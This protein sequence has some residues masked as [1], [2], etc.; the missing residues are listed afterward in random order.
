LGRR[1]LAP[2]AAEPKASKRRGLG[3]R[4]EQ[5][6]APLAVGAAIAHGEAALAERRDDGLDLACEQP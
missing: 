3:R 4:R 6:R 2:L 1:R 5:Q